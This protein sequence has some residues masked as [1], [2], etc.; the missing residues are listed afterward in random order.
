MLIRPVRILI[1]SFLVMLVGCS[2]KSSPQLAGDDVFFITVS[3][4]SVDTRTVMGVKNDD[5]YPLYWENCDRI[6]LNG[7]LSGELTGVD[8]EK[9]VVR[10]NIV[11]YPSAPYTVLYPGKENQ[12]GSVTFQQHQTYRK[13][14]VASGS[15]PMAGYSETLETVSLEPIGA[16]L[17]L[18]LTGATAVRGILTRAVAGEPLSGEYDLE[19]KS[20]KAPDTGGFVWLDASSAVTL[21]STPELFQISIP[22]GDR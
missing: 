6:S 21:S 8:T 17:Q 18:P 16:V 19:T 4:P 10:F 1:I 7:Y 15:L 13:G 12:T 20:V 11:G 3:T 5:R 2:E 9:A 22:A 14:S